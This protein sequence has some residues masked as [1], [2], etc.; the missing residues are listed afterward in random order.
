M[1]S[2][3]EFGSD[4]DDEDAFKPLAASKTRGRALKR[5]K[6]SQSDDEVDFAQGGSDEEFGVVDEGRVPAPWLFKDI[7]LTWPTFR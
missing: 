7:K 1:I 5:R 3:A 6:T 4:E 2:Y